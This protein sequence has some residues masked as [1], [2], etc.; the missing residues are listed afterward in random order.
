MA[1]FWTGKLT[2]DPKKEFLF[3]ATLGG[4]S[5][6]SWDVKSFT[7]PKISFSAGGSAL[8]GQVVF[9]DNFIL[10][11]RP[12]VEFGDVTVVFV[13]VGSDGIT[14]KL[15]EFISKTGYGSDRYDPYTAYEVIGDGSIKLEQYV[16]ASDGS[17]L[18]VVDTWTFY[19]V[20]IAD[21]DFGK[22]DYSSE[23]LSNVTISFS[24]M[25]L[26]YNEYQFGQ[27]I[28]PKVKDRFKQMNRA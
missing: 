2:K 15:I 10:K 13:D 18:E 21:I 8:D 6:L 14:S 22:N 26:K 5:D 28:G 24:Y 25:G 19:G 9:G 4:I 1:D 3:K 17:S 27:I 7:K 11:D 23:N 20:Q 12:S 16:N